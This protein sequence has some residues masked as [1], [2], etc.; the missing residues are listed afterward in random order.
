MRI[1]L[2]HPLGNTAAG[3]VIEKD[4]RRAQALIAMGYAEPAPDAEKPV[5]PQRGRS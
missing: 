1:R 2:L 4:D 5:K 3:A